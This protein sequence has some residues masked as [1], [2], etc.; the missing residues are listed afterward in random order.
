MRQILF[1]GLQEFGDN[2]IYGNLVI[3][4]DKYFIYPQK[5]A[6]G[7]DSP[8]NYHVDPK[9]VGQF[10]NTHAIGF[11][12]IFEGHELLHEN[13][14]K[15]VVEYSEQTASWVVKNNEGRI[16]D[17]NRSAVYSD[18]RGIMFDDWKIT[19]NIHQS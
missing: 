12:Y 8:D 1:R 3:Q 9:T 2:W 14:F 11:K 5:T 18:E 13:G 10:T 15:G 7:L 17:L 19:G 4:D 16:M 6:E